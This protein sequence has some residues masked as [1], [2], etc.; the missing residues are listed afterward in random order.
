MSDADVEVKRHNYTTLEYRYIRLIN[1]YRDGYGSLGCKFSQ[2]SLD[3]MTMT[4]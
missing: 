3:E 2:V 1:V 4:Y